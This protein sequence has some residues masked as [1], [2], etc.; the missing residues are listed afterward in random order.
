M[1]SPSKSRTNNLEI[2]YIESPIVGVAE[3]E[4]LIGLM[5]NS[6][7]KSIGKPQLSCKKLGEILLNVKII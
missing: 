6:S 3:F 7:Y 4:R 2:Q 1:T 5:K